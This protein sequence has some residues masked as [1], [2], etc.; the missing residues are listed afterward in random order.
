MPVPALH[1]LCAKL[2]EKA[3]A[4]GF[5][6]N[7]WVTDCTDLNRIIDSMLYGVDP[8]VGAVPFGYIT[9]GEEG[10]ILTIRGTQMPDGSLVEWLDDLDA[11]LEPCPFAPGAMWHR[12]FGAVFKSLYIV[13]Q[14]GA[15]KPLLPYLSL[16]PDLLVHGH[17][18]GGPLATFV[19]AYAHTQPPVLFASPKAGDLPL[20]SYVQ[21][22][23][24]GIAPSYANPNDAVPKVPITVDKP[25]NIEDFEQVAPFIVLS[26]DLVTPPIP[27][28][29]GDSHN[30]SN[31]RLLLEAVV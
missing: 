31:Y 21:A 7:P 18:L 23:T 27:S 24:G 19:A 22:A 3:Y 6:S 10:P 12:G 26:P 13:Q 1:V 30:L 29:W 15:V 17:S 11:F 2:G 16:F 14:G 20:R 4:E 5:L 9:L 25:W 28:S 8:K